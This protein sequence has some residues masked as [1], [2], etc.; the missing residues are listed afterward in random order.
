MTKYKKKSL[1]Q[2]GKDISHYEYFNDVTPNS[3]HTFANY[4]RRPLLDG[5]Y[6]TK[7][8]RVF[9]ALPGGDAATEGFEGREIE[10]FYYYTAVLG[11][12]LRLALAI[13]EFD[14]KTTTLFPFNDDT[15]FI[16][17]HLKDYL[18][19]SKNTPLAT[20][21]PGLKF[22][23]RN[24]CKNAD[25]TSSGTN[26]NFNYC[27]P[28]EYCARVLAGVP[29]PLGVIPGA[30]ACNISSACTCEAHRW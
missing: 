28:D 1:Y 20:R 6:G 21:V 25:G 8:M 2:I 26:P 12:D 7:R 27:K 22:I 4:V 18:T 19:D 5:E 3:V 29:H 14:L 23:N 24:N 11:W 15:K 30:P 16:T 17:S 10:T 9:R 13:D